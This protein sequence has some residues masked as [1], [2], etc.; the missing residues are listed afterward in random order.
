MPAIF[1]WLRDDRARD[2]HLALEGKLQPGGELHQGG[3]AASGRPDHGGKLAAV[4]VDREAV[5]C[6]RAACAAIDVTH[7]IERDEGGHSAACARPRGSG[8]PVL[9]PGF[10]LSRE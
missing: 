8:D 9:G 2:L 5:D 7:V 10:P 1:T 3:L 4:H 6:E